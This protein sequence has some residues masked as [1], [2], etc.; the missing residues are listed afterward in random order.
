MNEASIQTGTTLDLPGC[1]CSNLDFYPPF[2]VLLFYIS[3]TSYLNTSRRFCFISSN[4]L[5]LLNLPLQNENK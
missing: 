1:L 4:S 2:I 5:N 3:N